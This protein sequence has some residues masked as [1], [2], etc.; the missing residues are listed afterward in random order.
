MGLE[1]GRPLSSM[2]IGEGAT[3][4][5]GTNPEGEQTEPASFVN[6]IL[7]GNTE[8]AQWCHRSRTILG[9]SRVAERSRRNF[10]KIRWQANCLN[11]I[12][13][14]RLLHLWLG[15]QDVLSRYSWRR[16]GQSLDCRGIQVY[17]H[18]RGR[19]ILRMAV[20]YHMALLKFGIMTRSGTLR[21]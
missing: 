7:W 9:L 13:Q 4:R 1:P 17:R 5:E 6:R 3:L 12:C 20:N 15:C 19:F 14:R 2:W 11:S 21:Q 10:S 18:K 16:G 8:P